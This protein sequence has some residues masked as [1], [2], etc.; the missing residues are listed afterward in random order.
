M[1]SWDERFE[2]G[3]RM[4]LL[5][6]AYVR[7]AEI[8]VGQETAHELLRQVAERMGRAEGCQVL[9]AAGAHPRDALLASEALTRRLRAFGVG[10]RIDEATPSRV[11]GSVLKPCPL[12][13][14]ARTLKARELCDHLCPVFGRALAKAVNPRLKLSHALLGDEQTACRATL[15]EGSGP[16]PCRAPKG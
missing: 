4:A 6:M 11:T 14:A 8:E 10:C 15:S 2:A 12:Y 1:M 16:G 5:L 9:R 13:E 7:A 3:Y